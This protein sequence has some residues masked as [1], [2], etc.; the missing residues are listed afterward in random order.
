MTKAYLDT[1]QYAEARDAARAL[2]RLPAQAKEGAEREKEMAERYTMLAQA[3]YGSKQYGEAGAAPI[4][5][6]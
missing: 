2:L 4:P 6:W 5:M 3:A 1:R